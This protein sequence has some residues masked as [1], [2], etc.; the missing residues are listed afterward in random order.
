MIYLLISVPLAYLLGSVPTGY[1]FAKA[2]KGIDIREHG[3]GNVGATNVYRVV[4]KGPGLVVFALDLLKGSVAVMLIPKLMGSI[5]PQASTISNENIKILLGAAAI[6]GHIWTIF[7]RFKGG[8][9]VATTAG[10]MTALSPVLLLICLS[11]WIIV[12]SITHYVSMASIIASVCLP[13]VA[14]IMG[15]DLEFVLFCSILCLVGVF[16]HRANIKRLLRGE[17]KKIR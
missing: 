17:E 7:L 12:F 10:V 11:I 1:I 6:L 3:S 9:G 5:L 2:L 8:K 15:K 13:V 16:A 4:G 14:V